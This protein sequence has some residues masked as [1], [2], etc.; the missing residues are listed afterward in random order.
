MLDFPINNIN[1]L[2]LQKELSGREHLSATSSARS[3]RIS[4]GVCRGQIG[5]VLVF[6]WDDFDVVQEVLV[7]L[8]AAEVLDVLPHL[9]FGF[10]ILDVLL[11]CSE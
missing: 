7:A 8:V 11:D 1:R 3:Q 10:Q 4:I 9:F 2:N 5:R 6:H